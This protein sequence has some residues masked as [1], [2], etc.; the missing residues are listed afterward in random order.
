[1]SEKIGEFLGSTHTMGK[2]GIRLDEL[3]VRR[4]LAENRSRAQALVLAGQVRHGSHVLDKA[5]KLV[6]EDMELT[7]QAPARYVSR[8]A[9][10]L[11]GWFAAHPW[12]VAG[13]RF[14]DIGAST[15]GFTDYLLQAGAAEG[16]C[17]DVGRGQLHYR[18][19]TDPR[20]LNLEQVNARHLDTVPLP[21]PCYPLIVMDLS[22]ISLRLVLPA[23]WRRLEP[24]GL[25]VAL[26][27]PQFEAGK[28]E[29]DR[30]RG[31]IRDPELRARLRD[32]IL[33]FAARHLPGSRL[34]G[35]IE[36]PLAGADGNREF[37]AGWT[38]AAGP[39]A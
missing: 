20:I 5:G 14:L 34:V 22:F 30:A 3:L 16:T 26:I 7:V 11:A 17:V 39:A 15:G 12:P 35:W 19:R 31:V 8:G 4:G 18:L 32:G 24:G 33:E 21:H 36:S 9:D 28:Q 10:K 29:A 2:G 13:K 27:K 1:M 6:P 25:L 37:L 38:R 23:A